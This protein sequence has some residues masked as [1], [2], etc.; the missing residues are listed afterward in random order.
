VR[1]D[2]LED[3]LDWQQSL[4][5][6]AIDLGLERIGRVWRALGAPRIARRVV[7][8]AGT[9]GK[10]S[11]VAAYEAWLGAHGHRCGSYS[12]PHILRYN[13]RIRIDAEPL[14]D[15]DL[16]R[17]FDL[18]D[19]ARGEIPLTYFEF[20]ALAA[21]WLFAERAL[22]FALL[23]V[24]LGGR[25]DAVNIIDAD[26][27]HITPIGLDHQAW[28]GNDR[29]SIGREKAGILRPGQIAIYNDPEPVDSILDRAAELGCRLSLAGRDYHNRID[30]DLLDW[31]GRELACRL[32]APLPGWHQAWN[33]GGV[34]AGLEALGLLRQ[35]ADCRGFEGLRHPGRLQCLRQR[36]HELWVDVG[37]NVDAARA[38]ASFL[39]GR[40]GAGRRVL[41]LGMLEDK[42]P[43]AFVGALRTEI[44]DLWLLGLQG[45]RGLDAGELAR[46]LALPPG[47]PSFER[48]EPA[49]D[50]ALSTLGNQDILLA[51]GS[52]L[53]VEAVMRA[54]DGAHRPD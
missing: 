38:L 30:D 33:L 23:E 45:D 5:P 20:G 1:F 31:R 48:A 47:T 44:D 25:L 12:S 8:V 37:H 34:L 27:A 7:T 11:T 42:D 6:R 29:E 21:L 53:T 52:F 26:L 17:A 40:R 3:W 41:L 43:A 54:L 16:I 2:R 39:R 36:P 24:G 19:R 13:E 4:N 51:A 9:N 35:P 22:D 15:D 46:R 14:P 18:I 49:L 10:G 50:H 28:L 32:H